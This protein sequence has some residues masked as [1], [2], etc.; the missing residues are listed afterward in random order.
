MRLVTGDRCPFITHHSNKQKRML[1]SFLTVE[2]LKSHAS[3][4]ILCCLLVHVQV[5][6]IYITKRRLM[7]LPAVFHIL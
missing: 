7:L 6:T 4:I 1:C 5:Y 2:Q 3:L